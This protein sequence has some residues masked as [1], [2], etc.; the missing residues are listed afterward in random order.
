MVKGH[1]A[2]VADLSFVS[3]LACLSAFSSTFG[4]TQRGAS[5]I[6]CRITS[7]HVISYHSALH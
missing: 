5:V 2:W 6:S 4:R 3:C 7:D 1:Y